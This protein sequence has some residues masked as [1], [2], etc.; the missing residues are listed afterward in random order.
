MNNKIKAIWMSILLLQ[1]LMLP[2]YSAY[3]EEGAQNQGDT[4]ELVQKGLTIFEID[5]EVAR[6]NDQDAQIAE[7]I[8]QNERD[9]DNQNQ[10][11]AKT[12]KH[13]ARVV[14]AYY[15]GERDSIWMLMFSVTSFSDA[16]KMFE[17]LSMII[18]ND[19]R[20]LDQFTTS[21]VKLKALRSGLETSRL[22]LQQTKDKYLQ[23]R[24]RLV[25]LQEE[26]DKQLAITA[27]AKVIE[28]QINNVNKQWRDQGVPL[29][30]EYLRNLNTAFKD[31]PQYVTNGSNNFLDLSNLK[32][33]VITITDQQFNAYIHT[34]NEQLANLNFT[35][36][37]GSIEAQGTQDDVHVTLDGQFIL[38][39]NPD[40][41]EVRFQVNRLVFNGFELPDTTIDD[42][43]KEFKLGFIPRKMV[44]YMDVVSVETK[45]GVAT[46]KLKLML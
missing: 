7:Q 9:I 26:L 17:Y 24:T 38:I 15:T 12:R 8:K 31:L 41:N 21:F 33:P 27:Q 30:R 1:S 40:M 4:K 42:F 19:H 18:S 46:V 45:K 34:K 16:L 43:A 14:R 39:E 20:A 32:N 25:Q 28:E 13:A 11:V 44:S 35:F 36:L 2:S 23:Q 37:D 5:K 29:F 22:Q 6:L 3:A 10:D